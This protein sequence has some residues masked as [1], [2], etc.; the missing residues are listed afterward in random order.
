MQP[1][2]GEFS[3]SCYIRRFH[4]VGLTVE[5]PSHLVL[6]T[7]RAQ[8]RDVEGNGGSMNTR[9]TASFQVVKLHVGHMKFY[10]T[11]PLLSEVF[12]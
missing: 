10:Y 2:L 6:A 12:L 8:D 3:L 4:F 1:S 9:F 5:P 11:I 7:G